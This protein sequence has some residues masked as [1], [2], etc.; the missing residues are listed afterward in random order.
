MVELSK[1]YKIL[2][3]DAKQIVQDLQYSSKALRGTSFFLFFLAAGAFFISW[4]LLTYVPGGSPAIGAG[5]VLL[6]IG[7]ILG[8]IGVKFYIDYSRMSKRYRKLFA[9]FTRI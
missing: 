2:N 4:G 6:V 3:D 9:L 5:Y 7:I 1:I 8:A